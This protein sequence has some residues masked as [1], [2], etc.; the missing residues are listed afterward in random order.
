MGVE[1]CVHQIEGGEI[2]PLLVDPSEDIADVLH[3]PV[4]TQGRRDEL[5]VQDP[6]D[7]VRDLNGADVVG[8][9]IPTFRTLN[10][11][12]DPFPEFCAVEIVGLRKNSEGHHAFFDPL[13]PLL[14]G[15]HAFE[16]PV[17]HRVV[18]VHRP[19]DLPIEPVREVKKPAVVGFSAGEFLL[20]IRDCV[21]ERGDPLLS[22]ENCL[23][24]V[25]GPVG[26][27]DWIPGGLLSHVCIQLPE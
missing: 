12:L 16:R 11:L 18:V 5:V 22:V 13:F 1:E 20:W 19:I 7:L 8:N 17:V 9:Q 4:F 10:V 15:L 25:I 3:L 14:I 2:H 23:L 27:P 21:I 26:T 6:L 24:R